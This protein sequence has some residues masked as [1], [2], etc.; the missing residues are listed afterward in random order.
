MIPRPTIFLLPPRLSAAAAAPGGSWRVQVACQGRGTAGRSGFTLAEL[1]AVIVIIAVLASALAYTVTKA[2]AQARQTDCKSNLRQFGA[3]ILIYR[4]DHGNRNPA[5]LSSLYP[6]YVDDK[7]LFLCRADES[8]GTG[9]TR[10]TGLTSKDTAAAQKFPETVDNE[11]NQSGRTAVGTPFPNGASAA[12]NTAIRACSYFYEFSAAYCDPDWWQNGDMDGDGRTSWWEYKEH[13]LATGDKASGNLPYSSSR[14]PIIRCYHHWREG[15]IRGHP[16]DGG[17][18]AA[19]NKSVIQPFPITLN[20]AYAGNVYVG[21]L[22][23]EGALEPG[24]Q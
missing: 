5:W 18:P 10:P 23:W 17:S 22:W 19:V 2:R 12:A 1:L 8:R 6:E 7:H 15:R 16:D 13:Q 20:V 3:A 9:R 14:M 4:S 21:P 11:S 24:E